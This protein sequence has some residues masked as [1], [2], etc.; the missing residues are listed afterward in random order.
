MVCP[1]KKGVRAK[2]AKR[3]RRSG[4]AQAAG[5][6]WLG[7][8]PEGE[9]KIDGARTVS[10]RWT[11]R[12]THSPFAAGEVA[13]ARL[14]PIAMVEYE[15]VPVAAFLA[16]ED[17]GPVGRSAHRRPHAGCDV[18]SFVHHAL[19]GV[20]VEADGEV[21]GHPAADGPDR[22]RRCEQSL[23]VLEIALERARFLFLRLDLLVQAV[24][25]LEQV[26]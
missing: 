18:D 22:R 5:G 11:P 15:H 25:L 4:V 20:R 17:H 19:A 1:A 10:A 23:L 8:G 2:R 3:T 16:G 12:S 24:E 21:G 14:R 26:G 7:A 13:V 6:A 9:R